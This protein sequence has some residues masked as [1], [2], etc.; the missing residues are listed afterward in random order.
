VRI[1]CVRSLNDIETRISAAVERLKHADHIDIIEQADGS[2]DSSFRELAPLSKYPA[3]RN[4]ELDEYML[5]GAPR[6]RGLAIWWETEKPLPAVSGEF[7]LPGA[8]GL[9]RQKPDPVIGSM[10]DRF[11][12][13]F[14]SS[15]RFIDHS[16]ASSR[17]IKTCIRLAPESSPFELWH[18]VL[19]DIE[20]PPYPPGYLRLTLT[21]E[22]YLNH[23]SLTRGLHGWQYLFTDLDFYPGP[24]TGLLDNV[25]TGLEV[26]SEIFPDEDYSLFQRL[27]EVRS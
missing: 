7:R 6:F 27:L 23:L 22:E 11:Q 12:R 18:N 3:W 15:L 10:R 4:G 14:V 26:Y 24:Y 5:D 21:Y 16:F 17:G 2:V 13:E 20:V 19:E 25:R 8:L 1:E 9:L